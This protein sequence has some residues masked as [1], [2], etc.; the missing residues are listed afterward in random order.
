[1]NIEKLNHIKEILIKMEEHR[2]QLSD[3]EKAYN[4]LLAEDERNLWI[5]A[6]TVDEDQIKNLY[7]FY[8]TLE[9]VDYKRDLLIHLRSINQNKSLNTKVVSAFL[10]L[11]PT[12]RQMLAFI[13]KMK[14][15]E[16]VDEMFLFIVSFFKEGL[17]GFSKQNH[18]QL[19]KFL[20]PFYQED[21][22][23]LNK[24]AIKEEV[25]LLKKLQQENKLLERHYLT[26]KE[27]LELLS[28]GLDNKY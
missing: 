4:Q 5:L 16:K 12:R 6:K 15:T 23:P 24:Q 25:L 20:E 14:N 3:K 11:N 8:F 7:S 22:Y 17:G 2:V 13:E 21:A 18:K 9:E 27:M 1:M 19:L 26:K 10:E 28:I